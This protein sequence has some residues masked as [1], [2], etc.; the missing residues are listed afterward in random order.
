MDCTG[1]SSRHR[2]GVGVSQ[3]LWEQRPLPAV[4][5][6]VARWDV[7]TLAELPRVRAELRDL[8]RARAADVPAE[9]VPVDALLLAFD[10]L[11]SN[12]VRHGERPVTAQ[13]V[14]GPQGWLIDVSDQ[15]ATEPPLPAVDRDPAQGGLGLYLIARLTSAHGWTV[16]SGRKHVWALLEPSQAALV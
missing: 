6:E 11:L 8:L 12:A 5:G 4:D 14:A 1:R 10:E 2:D 16:R 9:V 3:P 13:L 15:D 7:N